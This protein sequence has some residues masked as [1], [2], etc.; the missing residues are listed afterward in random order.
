MAG[1]AAGDVEAGWPIIGGE[2]GYGAGN[3]MSA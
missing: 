2:S 1:A 3:E